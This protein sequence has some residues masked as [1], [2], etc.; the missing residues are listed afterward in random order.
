MLQRVSKF[1]REVHWIV[2]GHV[3]LWAVVD[4]G[5]GLVEASILYSGFALVAHICLKLF[6]LAVVFYLLSRQDFWGYTF[7]A[8]AVITGF[9]SSAIWLGISIKEFGTAL[10]FG[11]PRHGIE[12]YFRAAE[13][14]VSIPTLM[15]LWPEW[16]P[17][18]TER[19]ETQKLT[20]KGLVNRYVDV[21]RTLYRFWMQGDAAGQEEANRKLALLFFEAKRR[22]PTL[23][24]LYALLK[25]PDDWVRI[26]VARQ[27]LSK[28]ND[29][30][31]QRAG[32][33]CAK[34]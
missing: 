28:K 17:L 22:D 23:A 18:Y 5:R 26:T 2:F 9:S 1:V 14:I 4:F 15:A 16:W 24:S 19:T 30:S 12:S 29:S 20:D 33:D 10:A 11:D 32:C 21:A 6:Y 8:V 25:E 13:I 7:I 34:A 31:S 27:L 3:A